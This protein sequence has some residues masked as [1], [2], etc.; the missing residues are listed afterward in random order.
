M[1]LTLAH[2]SDVHLGPLPRFGVRHWGIKR[3]LGYLNWQRN[4]RD[5][6]RADVLAAL[7]ADLQAQ[8]PDHIAVTGDLVNI[9]LPKEYEAA[10]AW[11]RQLGDPDGV[12]VV[13]GNHDIYVRTGRDPG[14]ARW[15]A[16]MSARAHDAASDSQAGEMATD[17][18]QFPFVRR[19]GRVALI[20]LNSAVPTP[21]FV[22]AGNLGPEQLAQLGRRL[23]HL[24]QQGLTRVVLIHHPPLPGQA[25]R[26]KALRDAS[27]LA[28]VLQRHGAEL[29]LHGH[30][31]LS[32][33]RHHASS[34][35]PIPV[36]GVPSAS[37]GAAHKGEAL[38]RYHLYRFTPQAAGMLITCVS[39]GL[40]TSDGPV[41]EIE[42]R[43]LVDGSSLTAGSSLGALQR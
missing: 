35:G 13:P 27:A 33:L 25:S 17:A 15:Q 32:E 20:G 19:L 9:G 1:T 16:Y 2:L 23:E 37:L 14:V 41:V 7:V 38:A 6:H 22:A 43:T 10:L 12:T 3:G 11:L 8:R 24:G 42:R 18:G 4:R 21:P 30:N 31:H 28:D 40:A 26:L 36:V 34:A 39:R 29:V 5:A